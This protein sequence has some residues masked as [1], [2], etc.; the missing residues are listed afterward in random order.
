MTPPQ[1][2]SNSTASSSRPST[3]AI[4]PGASL[5][6]QRIQERKGESRRQSL[7]ASI[8]AAG[9]DRGPNSPAMVNGERRPSSSGGMGVKQV[10][11]VSTTNAMLQDFT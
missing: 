11:E 9:V 6:Q 3:G 10:E 5:L 8:G 2:S 1:S 7:R 4:A